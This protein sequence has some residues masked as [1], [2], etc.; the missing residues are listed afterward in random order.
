[1]DSAYGDNFRQDIRTIRKIIN[2]PANNIDPEMLITEGQTRYTTYRYKDPNFSILPY[3]GYQYTRADYNNL[4]KA[5][6]ILEN[7]LP[8][9]VFENVEF[10]LRSRIEYDYGN[11]EKS[12]DYGE[13]YSLKGRERL[14]FVYKCINK[15]VISVTYKTFDDEIETYELHPYLLK[16]YNNRWFLF[17]YRPENENC[18]W[19]VPLDRIESLSILSDVKILPRPRNY[20]QYFYDIIGVTKGRL[21]DCNNIEASEEKEKIVMKVSNIKTWKRLITKPIHKSQTIINEYQNGYGKMELFIVPNQEF[22]NSI[23]TVG[24]GVKIMKPVRVAQLFNEIIK[25]HLG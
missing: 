6:K 11:K 1:M 25:A 7:N 20:E 24:I 22:Y 14:P 13:N 15:S 10:A 12:I 5:L 18:Y 2:T 4:E 21:I 19:N 23:F 16:L 17:G 3:L 8:S 9:D